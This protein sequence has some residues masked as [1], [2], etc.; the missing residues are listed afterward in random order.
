VVLYFVFS[1][2]V[3]CTISNEKRKYDEDHP[4]DSLK[5]RHLQSIVTMTPYILGIY[6]WMDVP[7]LSRAFEKYQDLQVRIPYRS[8]TNALLF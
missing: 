5:N 1:Y 4:S 6:F 8:I 2:G 3:V 7:A